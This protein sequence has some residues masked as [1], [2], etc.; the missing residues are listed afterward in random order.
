MKKLAFVIEDNNDVS[1]LFFRAL[2][3][4][5]FQVEIISRGETALARLEKESPT[6]VI[7]DMHLPDI[8]G[9]T[10]LAFIRTREHLKD[11][12]VIIATADAMLG[13][14]HGHKADLL[15]EK[16]ISYAQMRDFA[17]RFS[18]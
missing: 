10:L 14:L 3:E 8:N 17:R 13:E 6:L 2:V 7:L 18:E 15:L 5:E 9:A 12:K 4:A 16:P 1:N 11:T